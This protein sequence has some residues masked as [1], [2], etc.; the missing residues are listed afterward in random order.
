MTA[1]QYNLLKGMRPGAKEP[2][3]NYVILSERM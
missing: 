1:A 2:P 3:P